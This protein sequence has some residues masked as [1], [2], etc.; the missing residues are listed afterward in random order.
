M[1]K[2]ML[3][4]NLGKKKG[5]T[6]KAKENNEDIL[7]SIVEPITVVAEDDSTH[8]GHEESYNYTMGDIEVEGIERETPNVVKKKA[9]DDDPFNDLEEELDQ[10]EDAFLKYEDYDPDNYEEDEE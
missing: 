4:T 1:P 9:N 8:T 2:K 6:S 10:D 7:R 5:V 3:N